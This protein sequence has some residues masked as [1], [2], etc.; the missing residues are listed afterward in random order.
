VRWH[1]IHVH[2]Y[3]SDKDALVLRAVR[4]LFRRVADRVAAAY[5][6]R[7]WRQGPH[8]RL[9]LRCDDDTFATVVWPAAR[10]IVGDFL[11]RH[12]ST[13]RLD[14][15]RE[16]AAHQG[17]AALEGEA[18]PLLPWYPDNSVRV[19]PYDAREQ[20]LGGPDLAAFLADFHTATTG[21]AFRVIEEVSGPGRVAVGFDLMIAA[22][23]V[24]SGLELTRAFVSF[25]SHAEGF[26]CGEF[27]DSAGL[28]AAWDAHYA[29][30]RAALVDRIGAVTAAL[31]AGSA[32]LPYV[33][34]W[35][36]VVQPLR[37]RAAR[38]AADGALSGG[39][40]A[41]GEAMLG[42]VSPFHRTLFANPKWPGTR[43]SP[44]FVT[45][46]L[47]LSLTYLLMTRVGIT[48]G[49]RFLLCH[50]AANAVEDRYG[51]SAVALV[52]AARR[53]TG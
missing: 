28:R 51:I 9:H 24:L 43:S 4:P 38:L 52:D 15:D 16:L 36:T 41:A 45:Y 11:A 14:P 18:G 17:L 12:P 27:P 50:L 19:A 42:A 20:A 13:R 46:R 1:S 5:F 40:D 53:G 31:A 29:G 32:A 2:Y 25:R 26:L 22:A 30:N 37:D 3:D 48:P 8:L 23:H 39:A 21:F 7:H 44:D 47:M 35:L 10:D 6:T 34:D 49:E 33:H